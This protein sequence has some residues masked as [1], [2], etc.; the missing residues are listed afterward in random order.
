MGAEGTAELNP[1]HLVVHGVSGGV[2]SPP[3]ASVSPQLLRD[4]ESVLKLCA[5]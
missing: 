5:V 1:W 2:V 4:E 3:H